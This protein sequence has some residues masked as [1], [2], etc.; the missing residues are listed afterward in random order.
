[1]LQIKDLE[2]VL[3]GEEAALKPGQAV[4]A[5]VERHELLEAGEDVL[6]E[7]VAGDV[8]VRDVEQQQVIQPREDLT[9]EQRQRVVLEIQLLESQGLVENGRRQR[10]EAVMGNIQQREAG[11]AVQGRGREHRKAVTLKY[12]KLKPMFV[13]FRYF[14]IKNR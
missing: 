11:E 10:C 13:C 1:M 2:V 6:G 4:V 12:Y 8:I 7:E 14:Q 9:G 3:L 5:E